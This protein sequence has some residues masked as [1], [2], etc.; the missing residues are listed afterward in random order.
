MLWLKLNLTSGYGGG[1]RFVNMLHVK[2]MIPGPFGTS[3]VF[4]LV[5]QGD[6]DVTEVQETVEQIFKMIAESN[7][8]PRK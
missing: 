6:L 4:N 1:T 7:F 8:E 5:T 2:E 3:L